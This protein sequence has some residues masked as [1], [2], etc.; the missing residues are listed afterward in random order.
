MHSLAR[1]RADRRSVSQPQ[2]RVHE[3]PAVSRHGRGSAFNGRAQ[4]RALGGLIHRMPW[5]AWLTLIGALAMAGLPPLNGFVSEW[6][7]LQ[8][9]L[10]AHEVPR[11]FINMILPL[12]AALVALCC[13]AC[14]LRHGQ[15]FRRH[16]PRSAARAHA[17]A[18]TRCRPARAHRPHLAR[19]RLLAA[20]SAA[21]V[22]HRCTAHRGRAI[23]RRRATE[24]RRR[25]GGYWCRCPTGEPPIPRP[26]FSLHWRAVVVLTA[27][28]GATLLP[29]PRAAR[30]CL[31]LRLRAPERAHA[32]YRRRLRSAHPSHLRGLLRREARAA[33]AFDSA[34]RYQRC[35]RGSDLAGSVRA[36]GHARAAHRGHVR[37]AAAG[38][39]L[40]LPAVQLRHAHR[41][42][43]RSCYEA[44][45]DSH[46][47]TRADRSPRGRTAV[48]RLGQPVPRLAA[49]PPRAEHLAALP[50][51][52]QALSQGCGDRRERLPAF[53]RGAL[54]RFRRDGGGG[55]HHSLDGHPSAVHDR[56]GCHRARGSARHGASLSVACRDGHRHR[57][58]HPRRAARNDGGFSRRA[59]LADGHLRRVDDFGDHCA[60]GHHRESR[61]ADA[62]VFIRVSRSL[63][64]RSRWCCS[65]RTRAFPSTIRQ[66]T[67][68]SR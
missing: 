42:S 57:L 29:S 68:S 55:G 51:H 27:F 32:G 47:G 43:W 52:S 10:F 67:S 64:S 61:H 17:G 39:D 50:R 48:S 18:R 14:R 37:L 23:Q 19:P 11:T 62:R 2:S 4:P 20:G 44:D 59:R 60:S 56:G 66:R 26:S 31:G 40:D 1:A 33:I 53:S 8:A 13:R 46:P 9:F 41:A 34:P 25:P 30:R 7:L 6:L 22:R 3:E 5:V 49:E 38:T 24:L 35:S 58:R 28:A 36:L 45:R 65:P 21:H 15:V 54:R 16:L 12:G 63:P